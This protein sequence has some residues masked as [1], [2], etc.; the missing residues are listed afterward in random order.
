MEQIDCAETS[1]RNSHYTLRNNPEE[2][3][4]PE[5]ARSSCEYNV[6]ISFNFFHVVPICGGIHLLAIRTLLWSV[7]PSW[8]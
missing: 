2:R 1:V 5:I 6:T 3:Q 8:K 7:T 4:K